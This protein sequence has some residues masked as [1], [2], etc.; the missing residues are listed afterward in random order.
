MNE[1]ESVLAV[2]RKS[3]VAK[4]KT[5]TNAKSSKQLESAIG[6]WTEMSDPKVFG[7]ILNAPNREKA[8]LDA[9]KK[10][11]LSLNSNPIP[12]FYALNCFRAYHGYSQY[13]STMTEHHEKHWALMMEKCPVGF[14]G[15]K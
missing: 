8:V 12:L 11:R 10:L 9:C 14:F 13:L 5:L 7:G 6:I 1:V 4:L 15:K 2:E 3:V